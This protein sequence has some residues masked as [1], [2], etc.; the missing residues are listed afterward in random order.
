MIDKLEEV[1]RRFERL[2]ADLSNPETLGDSSKLL[3]V[4]KE[5]AAL[6]KLVD[7]F[8]KDGKY[9][10]ELSYIATHGT[11]PGLREQLSELVRTQSVLSER[12]LERHAPDVGL[13]LRERLYAA[14]CD[15]R[16]LAR[17]R[18]GSA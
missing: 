6:E 16:R 14:V 13:A 18:A 8:R 7:A 15:E 4:S 9:L 12:Y 1:E 10:I 3:K 5:R 11:V 17:R 2:T